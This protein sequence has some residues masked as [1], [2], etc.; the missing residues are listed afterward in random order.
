MPTTSA[1]RSPSANPPTP[2]AGESGYVKLSDLS[3]YA[4]KALLFADVNKGPNCKLDEIYRY[5]ATQ[6]WVLSQLE[7]VTGLVNNLAPMVLDMRTRV[8]DLEAKV[9]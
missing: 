8:T 5:T 7:D 6:P 4:T 1:I 2:P 3:A 9:G